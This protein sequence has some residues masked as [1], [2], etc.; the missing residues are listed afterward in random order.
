MKDRLK[1][2]SR[3]LFVRLGL[4]MVIVSLVLWLTLGTTAMEKIVSVLVMP[5]GLVWLM[6][7][8]LLVQAIRSRERQFIVLS[9]SVW[10]IYSGAGN[11]S[12]A[13]WMAHSR[14][15][16]YAEIQPLEEGK[17]DVVILLGGGAKLGASGRNQGNASGDRLILAA[18]MYHQG[19]ARKI[20]CTGRRAPELDA[21]AVDP[22]E[23]SA[24]VLRDLGVPP[25]VIELA[26]GRNT[27][28]EMQE[29]A[30]RFSKPGLRVGLLTS[31]WHLP[32][33]QRLARKHDFDPEPLPADFIN[34]P[35]DAERAT[36]AAFL[37]S[38]VPSAESFAITA[39]VTKE[40][41]AALVGR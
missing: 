8:L 29:L 11:R 17:F 28:E 18:Q 38:F 13:N 22:A 7:S 24:S 32:R 12:I 34:R 26:G 20:V 31:A 16:R 3:S 10:L 36:A 40:Y 6:L 21:R 30:E 5:V 2:L 25:D 33:A 1:Q 9:A 35:E 37:R 41:L 23:R 19:S 39:K 4:L 27:S 14:E 15:G